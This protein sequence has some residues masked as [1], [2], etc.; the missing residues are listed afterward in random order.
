[1]L[2]H[3]TSDGGVVTVGEFDADVVEVVDGERAG[4]HDGAVGLAPHGGQVGIGLVVDL[5]DEFLDEV[6]HRDDAGDTAVFVHDDRHL[7][8]TDLQ[9]AHGGQDPGRLRE[10]RRRP[11]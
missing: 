5:A 3:E 2:E 11:G 4:Q 8:P 9:F 1:M 6:F 7:G 10:D